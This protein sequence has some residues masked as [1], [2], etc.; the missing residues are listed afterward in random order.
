MKK[1]KIGVLLLITALA[2]SFLTQE[3]SAL[4]MYQIDDVS[5]STAGFNGGPFLVTP[6]SGGSSF[7]TFCLEYTEYF[8]PGSQ[9]YGTIESG[10]IGGGAGGAIN[11]I[12]PIDDRTK[13]LYS[14][15]LDNN[16]NPDQSTALQLAIWMIENEIT[17]ISA[18]PDQ[19]EALVPGYLTIASN[20]RITHNIQ[21]L[22]LWSTD[23]TP[24]SD[25]SLY[26]LGS[27][28]Q[29]QLIA[30]PEPSTL[31]LLG[32]GLIGLGIFGRKRFK[33]K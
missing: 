30:V 9:Y 22:N 16:L 31:L 12:D 15:Y 14:Y 21:A 29:S 26:P 33:T 17:D 23:F 3:L 11:N 4:P 18:Y 28:R 5:G 1:F 7:Q 13:A 8:N 27:G 19:I 2:L 32:A 10:A 6:L 25:P 20:Y 24:P